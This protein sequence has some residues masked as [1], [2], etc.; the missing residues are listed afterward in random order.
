MED[1]DA[2][3]RT[4]LFMLFAYKIIQRWFIAILIN[5][6]QSILYSKR[7]WHFNSLFYTRYGCSPSKHWQDVKNFSISIFQKLLWEWE[8]PSK[9]IFNNFIFK[10]TE[11][12]KY[13][14]SILQSL[15][16]NILLYL[17]NEQISFNWS[18]GLFGK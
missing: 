4:L 9:I 14:T 8:I 6:S 5:G 18:F 13:L 11:N 12:E 7:K 16:E 15:Y 17:S 1:E 2:S 3:M 10:S